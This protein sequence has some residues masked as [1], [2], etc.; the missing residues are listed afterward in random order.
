MMIGSIMNALDGI[1]SV[2]DDGK[3]SW[4]DKQMLVFILKFIK[5]MAKVQLTPKSI[6]ALIRV[7]KEFCSDIQASL[8][9]READPAL[10][11]VLDVVK[12]V[13][14]SLDKIL[15]EKKSQGNEWNQSLSHTNGM[16]YGLNHGAQGVSLAGVED[17]S[18]DSGEDDIVEQLGQ[19][20]PIHQPMN[21][22]NVASIQALSKVGDVA[23]PGEL[24]KNND[25]LIKPADDSKKPNHDGRELTEDEHQKVAD[26]MLTLLEKVHMTMALETPKLDG[27]IN[28][29]D[30]LKNRATP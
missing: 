6:S 19:V 24:P 17:V 23:K 21:E 20:S 4:M 3:I 15:K 30:K 28:T 26:I 8:N 25:I 1:S 16:Q 10:K 27:I 9:G 2:L 12:D 29:L 13:I 11:D 7:L 18:S 5:E 22:K 14:R